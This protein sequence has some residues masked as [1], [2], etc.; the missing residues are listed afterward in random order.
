[1]LHPDIV[2]TLPPELRQRY[3][4]VA[5][6]R[7]RAKMALRL[8]DEALRETIDAGDRCPDE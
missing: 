3:E 6:T 7:A 4:E 2:E 1:M 8:Y 5:A